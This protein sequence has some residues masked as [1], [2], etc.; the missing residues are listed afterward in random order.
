MVSCAVK[1][2]QIQHPWAYKSSDYS[3]YKIKNKESFAHIAKTCLG[4]ENLAWKIEEANDIASLR[5]GSLVVVPLKERHKGGLFENGYQ[6][7]PILC[8]HKFGPRRHSPLTMP[9]DVF[10]K[11]MKY[12]KDNG[13]RVI[14]PAQLLC[15]LKYR[16]EIPKKSVMITID[17]GYKSVYDIAWPILK[18]YNFTATLFVYINY[19]GISKKA[20][21]W[22]NLRVLKAHG[23]T[24]GSHTVSHADLTHKEQGEKTDAFYLRIKRELLLSKQII[25]KKLGQNT[26]VLAFPYGRS[27]QTVL[28]TAKSV[29]YKIAVTVDRGSNPFFTNS[30]ALKR[31][32]ILKKDMTSFI[33]RLKTFNTVS[34][35]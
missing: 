6:C 35:R 29:G 4:N 3:L 33:S 18:K 32:M 20:L 17:D 28:K 12:L 16:C 5:D 25:D 26:I 10:N 8:Y 30:L 11:Q 15:F 23:F 9:P 7:I 2:P 22:D 27:N 21:S 1:K 24:I 31:D 13:Y 19:I 34:L 14:N